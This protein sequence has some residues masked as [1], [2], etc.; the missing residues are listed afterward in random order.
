MEN[1]W[2]LRLAGSSVVRVVETVKMAVALYENNMPFILSEAEAILRMVT[3]IDYIGIVPDYIFPR[4][5]HGYFPK[6]D[7][8]IDFMQLGF[9]EDKTIIANAYWYPL[10]KREYERTRVRK[11]DRAK[12]KR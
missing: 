1:K 10:E 12:N 2:S 7:E 4:Y 9:E 11:N 3:G 8:I 6:D 5:C